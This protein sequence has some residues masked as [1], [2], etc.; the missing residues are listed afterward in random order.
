MRHEKYN[1][2]ESKLE[3][4]IKESPG[5]LRDI[6]MISWVAKR[7]FDNIDLSSLVNT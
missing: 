4:N 1:D 3:P 2:S 6:Q 5:G 7:H